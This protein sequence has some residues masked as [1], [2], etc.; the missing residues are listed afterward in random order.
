M[1]CAFYFY[2]IMLMV[3]SLVSGRSQYVV[4][5]AEQHSVR[6]REGVRGERR[7]IATRGASTVHGTRVL[8]MLS[9]L[10]QRLQ[11]ALLGD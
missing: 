9:A 6:R 8:F 2:G 11:S 1:R 5:E 4:V 10:Q 7:T 3:N